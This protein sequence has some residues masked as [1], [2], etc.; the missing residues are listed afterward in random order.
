MYAGLM[1][2]AVPDLGI[3]FDPAFYL[4]RYPDV[5]PS[6]LDPLA[7]FLWFGGQEGRQPDACFDSGFYLLQYPDVAA[8][9]S[10]PLVHFLRFGW[11]EGRRPNE[12]FDPAFYA[13][14][15]GAPLAYRNP[16]VDY[17]VRRR[18]GENPR[19]TIPF[20]LPPQ[21]YHV[22]TKVSDRKYKAVD[23]VIPVYRGLHETRRCLESLLGSICRTPY[24]VVLINDQTPDPELAQYLRTLDGQSGILLLE[25]D[26]NLGFAGSVNRALEL[27]PGRDVVLLNNDTEVA[28]DWLDRLGSAAFEPLE[29]QDPVGT[30]TPFSNNATICSYPRMEVANPLPRGILL[31]EL[32][33]LFREVNAGCRV[34]IPT[35][36]GFCMYIRREC[37]NQV[38]GFRAEIFGKGYGE[39]ND[40]CLR[41]L[42]KGYANV[43]AADVFVYHAGETSFGKEAEE[44][45]RS[46][47]EHIRQLYPEYDRSIAEHV[48][49]DPAKPFRVA[50]SAR[51][52][53]ESGRPVILSI[54][55]A[56][57]GGIHQYVTELRECVT[58]Q[59][60]MLVLTPG[61]CDTVVLRNLD[62]EDDFR[63]A[64]QLGT[65]YGTLLELLRRCGVTRI[66]VQHLLGHVLDVGRLREDLSADLDY[67]VHDYFAICPQVTLTDASGRYCE[68][69]DPA[70]CNACLAGRPPWPR[71]DIEAWRTR[72]GELVKG[73][74]RIIAPSQDAAERMRRYFPA[75]QI[76]AAAH[77][78]KSRRF[79]DPSPARLD[80]GD[81]LVIAVLGVMN[82]H[83]GIQ[84]LRAV[85][86]EVAAR[87]LPVRLVLVGYVD[88]RD[89]G[90]ESFL[91]TGPYNKDEL[92]R[93]LREAGAQ[94]VW[95][96]A[97]WPET[98]SYTLSACFEMEL[99]VIVPDM[100]AFP[101]RVAGRRWS[102]VTPW[103]WESQRMVEFF[104]E[105]RRHLIEG[106]PPAVF[107]THR[108]AAKADFY[109]AEYLSNLGYLPIDFPRLQR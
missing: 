98:F 96:P 38:G 108:P 87:N 34:R 92:P 12:V 39:E 62:P 27:D 63:V 70:A 82:R 20:T 43:L 84:R 94:V 74:D 14:H 45:R 18:R 24:R 36:V 80:P 106:T 5:G 104:L 109:P 37:L 60:E 101:E 54:T 79:A 88:G 21:S 86:K 51:R 73:A 47:A 102:W 81:P 103:D 9:G 52:M 68:E 32:D 50:V 46:G 59:A 75:A 58:G 89:A 8:A 23:V 64:F 44:R 31:G 53:K 78:G 76:V 19:S 77:P 93:L 49:S 11:Q 99:P 3:C 91:Q 95:F 85:A 65:D 22:A 6:G 41:A 33:T 28:H 72:Y 56:L 25:N 2:L 69:P 105:V 97:Q 7:H 17:T 29:N 107:D 26:R 71:L 66:H 83:K 10:N 90:E 55:H 15:L 4:E 67:S 13:A 57:G 42:Y 1:C 100:G 35:G 48:R 30:V 16:F 40:F 61:N